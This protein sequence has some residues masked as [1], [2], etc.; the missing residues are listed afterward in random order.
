M[1]ERP[2]RLRWPDLNAGELLPTVIS[3]DRSARGHEVDIALDPQR[4]E[5]MHVGTAVSGP[6]ELVRLDAA[7]DPV[8]TL[9]ESAIITR[10]ALSFV[11]GPTPWR[12]TFAIEDSTSDIARGAAVLDLLRCWHREASA[13]E[14]ETAVWEADHSAVFMRLVE[15]A[16]LPVSD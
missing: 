8:L 5:R 9:G 7:E 10:T 14:G 15:R 16:G 1:S 12:V 2:Y 6:L 11:A 4:G 3:Y 13:T